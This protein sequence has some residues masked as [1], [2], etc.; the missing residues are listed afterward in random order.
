MASQIISLVIGS[1]AGRKSLPI[2]QTCLG[3]PHPVLHIT[4]IQLDKVL[5]LYQDKSMA[6]QEEAQAPV[7]GDF[8]IPQHLTAV[9]YSS[10][11]QGEQ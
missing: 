10:K 4:A 3:I 1:V 8:S 11:G 9:S 5:Y 6:R 2:S 7:F